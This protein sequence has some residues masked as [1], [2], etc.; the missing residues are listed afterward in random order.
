MIDRIVVDPN[1]HFGKPCVAGTRIT[2][3]SV[4]ELLDA[5]LSFNEIIQNYYPDL[6]IDDIRACI[7]YAIALVAAEDVRLTTTS[8]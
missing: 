8:A 1:I 3:Q 2:V 4:L 5:G 7:R 6:Q